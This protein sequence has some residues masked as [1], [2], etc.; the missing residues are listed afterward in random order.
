MK[1]VKI[2]KL[3]YRGTHHGFEDD[4]Y[5]PKVNGKKRLL[6]YVKTIHGKK[7]GGYRSVKCI[8]PEG[9]EWR[10]DKDA[11]LFKLNDQGKLIVFNVKDS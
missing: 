5:W 8:R 9:Y 1:Y 3:V 10:E 11:C 4:D 2:I 6:I 7:F